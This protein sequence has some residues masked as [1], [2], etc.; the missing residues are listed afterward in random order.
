MMMTSITFARACLLAAKS[1][2]RKNF[3]KLYHDHRAT[4]GHVDSTVPLFFPPSVHLHMTFPLSL[5][6]KPNPTSQTGTSVLVEFKKPQ[7][8]VRLFEFFSLLP[9]L[10][11]FKFLLSMI[12]AH[13]TIV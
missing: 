6:F 4:M 8:A 13:A 2:E 1:N 10:V 11:L 5:K 7:T 3:P 9:F 12:S